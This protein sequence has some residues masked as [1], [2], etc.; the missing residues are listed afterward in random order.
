MHPCAQISEYADSITENLMLAR[1]IE[2]LGFRYYWVTEGLRTEDLAYAPGN[3]G[4]TT[5][6]TLEHI[7]DLSKT[8]L[9]AVQGKPNVRSEEAEM[10]FDARRSKALNNFE[11]AFTI[12][13]QKETDIN[14]VKI[15]F[16]R[17]EKSSEYPIWNLINGPITDAIYH[18][19]QIVSFRRSSGN[20]IRPGVNVFSGVQSNK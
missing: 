15:I 7:Y 2:G 11:A 10:N 8:I 6:E 17:G 19:R 1:M 18:C 4:R 14:K 16:Q 12:L 9:N 5:K 13:K 3:D 20:P